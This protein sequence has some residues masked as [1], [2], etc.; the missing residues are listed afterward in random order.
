[1]IADFLIAGHA[2]VLNAALVTRDK[3]R[4]A[5]YFPELTLITPESDNG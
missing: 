3:R 1:M 2:V 4:I 5:S